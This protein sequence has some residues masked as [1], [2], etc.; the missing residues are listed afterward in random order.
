M[1]KQTFSILLAMQ[2]LCSFG[3]Y[4]GLCCLKPAEFSAPQAVKQ[5]AKPEENLP[6]CHRKKATEQAVTTQ[7]HETHSARQTHSAHQTDSAKQSQPKSSGRMTASFLHRNCCSM[8]RETPDGEPLPGI[9]AQ[10][11]GKLVAVIGALPWL[12]AE[13][14]FALPTIPIQIATTHS[15]PHTGFQLSLRI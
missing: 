11:T 8:K 7:D 1:I 2:L 6:P 15:P 10:Q 3:L 13:T 5:P 9:T 12:D 4:S 14:A